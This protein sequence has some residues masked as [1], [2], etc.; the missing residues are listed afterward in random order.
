MEAFQQKTQNN[1]DLFDGR[2]SFAVDIT[3][4]TDTCSINEMLLK[5]I[6]GGDNIQASAKYIRDDKGRQKMKLTFFNNELGEGCHCYVV[7]MELASE[8]QSGPPEIVPGLSGPN[9]YY[10]GSRADCARTG[11]PKRN[12]R[13]RHQDCIIRH[14]VGNQHRT[15]PEER[16]GAKKTIAA[17]C[18]TSVAQREENSERAGC[19]ISS[20]S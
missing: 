16:T 1:Y 15:K 12:K 13:G 18:G 3:E 7:A 8:K 19:Q 10:M 11:T 14:K 9:T 2:N 5:S 4:N 6:T 17:E 20:L